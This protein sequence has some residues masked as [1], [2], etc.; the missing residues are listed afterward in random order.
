MF[1]LDDITVLKLV[2]LEPEHFD[3]Y[4]QL[5][6][7]MKAKSVFCGND[8]VQIGSLSYGSVS[9]IKRIFAKPTHEGIFDVFGLIFNVTK[10]QI[11]RANVTSYFY[12]LN[13]IINAVRSLTEKE[14]KLL[15]A[16]ADKKHELLVQ[17]GVNRLQVFGELPVLL[18]LGRSFSIEPKK[19]NDW[20]YN[21]VLSIMVHD[22]ITEE[23]LEDYNEL[24]KQ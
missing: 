22:K 17:A 7:V 15:K 5:Q 21:F 6:N 9:E 23:I 14:S 24:N 18:S 12:A 13:H 2:K 11:L 19:I 1:D 16:K 3:K 4:V 10:N 20:N 8:A